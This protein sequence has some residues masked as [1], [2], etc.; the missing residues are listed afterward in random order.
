MGFYASGPSKEGILSAGGG[1]NVDGS[2]EVGTSS[3]E[4]EINRHSAGAFFEDLLKEI[5][6]SDGPLF[7]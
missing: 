2:E 5:E 4:L 3:V 7:E 1:K 6:L